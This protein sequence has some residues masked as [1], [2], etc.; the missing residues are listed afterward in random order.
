MEEVKFELSVEERS[1]SHSWRLV[2]QVV[3]QGTRQGPEME[4][5]FCSSTGSCLDETWKKWEMIQSW[6]RW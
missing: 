4:G 6:I 2:W 3:R 1:K 5:Y